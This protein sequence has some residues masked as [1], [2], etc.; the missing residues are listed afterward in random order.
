VVS[1]EGAVAVREAAA[2][3]LE[4]LSLLDV[5]PLTPSEVAELA[6]ALVKKMNQRGMTKLSSEEQIILRLCRTV[7]E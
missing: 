3:D 4:L 2:A 5:E 6:K 7:F 1:E